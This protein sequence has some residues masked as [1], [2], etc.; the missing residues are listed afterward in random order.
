MQTRIHL[1][2]PRTREEQEVAALTE[3]LVFCLSGYSDD[4]TPSVPVVISALMSTI[5]QIDQEVRGRGADLK[6]ARRLRET[7]EL[8]ESGRIDHAQSD[9]PLQ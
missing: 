6:M 7:A 9:R 4:F 2:R 8:I 5:L 3:F 1:G